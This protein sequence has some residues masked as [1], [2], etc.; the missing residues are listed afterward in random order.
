MRTTRCAR[1]GTG[2]G[3]RLRLT[4]T[5]VVARDLDGKVHVK[6]EWSSGA[7]IGAVAGGFLGLLTSFLFP[8]VGTAAGA[9]A[10]AWLGSTFDT[11]V[12]GAFVGDIGRSLRPGRSALFLMIGEAD[13]AALRAALEPYAGQGHVLQMTLSSEREEALRQALR[14]RG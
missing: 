12:D 5:A 2:E 10:G 11:G 7:K 14:E 6:N 4:D 9:A 1:W 8:V 3:G 13:P